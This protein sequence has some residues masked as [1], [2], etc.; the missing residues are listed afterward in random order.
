MSEK[1]SKTEFQNF[2]LNSIKLQI[3]PGNKTCGMSHAISEKWPLKIA[4]RELRSKILY[5]ASSSD[6]IISFSWILSCAKKLNQV[7]F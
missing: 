1:R 2:R 3:L 4:N 6:V 5:S 7:N